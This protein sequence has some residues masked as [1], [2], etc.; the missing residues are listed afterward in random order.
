MF[1]VPVDALE[2]LVEELS[3][4]PAGQSVPGLDDQVV[5]SKVLLERLRAAG[6]TWRVVV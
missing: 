5:P 3:Q 4:S 1:A 2:A 6:C